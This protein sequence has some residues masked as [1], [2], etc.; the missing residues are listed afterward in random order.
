M[1]PWQWD[2]WVA[3]GLFGQLLFGSR[4]IIQWISSE[5]RKQSHIP[6]MFWYISLAGG[7]V[8]AIYAVHRRDPVF[9][10]GQASGLIVYVRNLM[11]IY[12]SKANVDA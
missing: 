11:L 10:I 12:S 5:R 4:F 7:I 9:V 6:V 1:R 3:F 8:T 2:L